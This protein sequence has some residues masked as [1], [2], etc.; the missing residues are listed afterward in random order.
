ME[1]LP[2]GL[3]SGSIT[4]KISNWD[5]PG[6]TLGKVVL[7]AGIGFGGLLLYK[8][9]PFLVTMASNIFY[10]T[11]FGIGTAFL[12]FLVTNKQFRHA[13]GLGYFQVM[14]LVTNAFIDFDPVSILRK[15][16][17]DMQVKLEVMA[18]AI[19][20]LNGL[21]KGNQRDIAETTAECEKSIKKAQWL[22]ENNRADEAMVPGN[23]A[24]RK[25]QYIANV[26]KRNA[27]L[28]KYL[29]V[30]RKL[31]KYANL[32]IQDTTN[33]IK[34]KEKEFESI[35]KQHKAF[36]AFMSIM[37]G[38]Q[39][40]MYDFER[41]METMTNDMDAR[42]GEMDEWISATGDIMS[43]IDS[44]NGVNNMKVDELLK[45]YTQMGDNIFNSFQIN[46]TVAIENNK[47]STFDL[48]SLNN[49]D[50]AELLKVKSALP[51]N[52]NEKSYF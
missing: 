42:L 48:S 10:L 43:N 46:E 51:E 22:T 20:D 3:N 28:E 49:N 14:R 9:L 7:V 17:S 32:T 18:K 25:K 31:Y 34:D 45:K 40:Q 44:E 37:H 30:L 50:N 38:D 6:G 4:N 41:A 5:R 36:K 8:A 52:T 15:R 16:V 35:K 27:E 24:V 12:L 29:E 26:Q 39:D 47:P 21:Y 19:S 11:S 2:M 33:C 13:L 23:D 1:N